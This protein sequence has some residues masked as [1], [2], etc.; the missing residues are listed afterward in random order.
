MKHRERQAD[1]GA[2]LPS[3]PAPR[4]YEPEALERRVLLSINTTPLLADRSVPGTQWTYA[5]T[6]GNGVS[7]TYV[8]TVIG[9]ATFNGIACIEIDSGSP[10]KPSALQSYEGQDSAGD[11]VSY[12]SVLNYTQMDV[13]SPYQG[14]IPLVA[15]AGTPYTDTYTDTDTS[16]NLA[17][18]NTLTSVDM[19]TE[20][21]TLVSETP[22]VLQ[23]PAGSYSAYDFR[24]VQ[25]ITTP[26]GDGTSTTTT[27][28]TDSWLAP[29]VGLV[30]SDT[31][32]A[33]LELSAFRNINDKLAFIQQPSNVA[34]GGTVQPA[35][36]VAVEDSA[37][38]YDTSA[39]GTVAISLNTITGTGTLTGTLTEPV[40]NGFATFSDLSVDTPGQY[41]LA[42]ADTAT[43]PIA[44]ATSVPFN[45]QDTR[46]VFQVAPAKSNEPDVALAPALKVELQDGKGNLI[47][48][49]DGSVVT[50]SLVGVNAANPITG[51]TATLSGGIAT[52][53]DVV[54][55]KP[56]TYQLQAS[57]AAGDIVAT[58]DKFGVTG[59][60]LV[61][62]VQPRSS[63]AASPLLM[64]VEA[65]T[66][67]GKPDTTLSETVQLSLNVIAG[68]TS[69]VLAGNAT[70]TLVGGVATFNAASAVSI[71]LSGTYTLTATAI[72]SSGVDYSVK[73]ATSGKFKI[74]G[75]TLREI[76]GEVGSQKQVS[77]DD[78]LSITAANVVAV[79][80]SNGVML[81]T[82]AGLSPATAAVLDGIKWTIV[83]NSAD[84]AAG[85][86][87]TITQ[88]ASKPLQ[89]TVDLNGEGS[90]NVICY[91][92]SNGNG[93]YD[94]G[95]ELKVFHLAEVGVVVAAGAGSV[96]TDNAD[97]AAR[98]YLTTAT[99]L[100]DGN[101]AGPY[102]I[103]MSEPVQLIGGGADG[104]I[105]VDKI[106]MGFVQ[107]GLSDNFAV[108]YK[109]G[110]VATTRL[111]AGSYPILDS[112]YHPNPGEPSAIFTLPIGKLFPLPK[113]PGPARD[114]P[115]TADPAGGEDRTVT[116]A[117]SPSEEFQNTSRSSPAS[118][119]S[120][121]YTFVAY[122]SAYSD[123]FGQS[124]DGYLAVNWSESFQFSSVLGH[125][126]NLGSAVSSTVSVLPAPATLES[127]G[128]KT[129]GPIFPE[130]SITI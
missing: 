55:T 11:Y 119:T 49:S 110:N 79:P 69:A 82:A 21:I 102:A 45:V 20:V 117:D 109:N 35:V 77:T 4:R 40:V 127:L 96:T 103:Q 107:D 113:A 13:Y 42:A 14:G 10:T 68:H 64:K 98:P 91:Y 43:P 33:T 30:Q 62:L 106:H 47:T 66:P 19:E 125:W 57:D 12:G 51:T 61:Y 116:T 92:D 28:T 104:M 60:K 22:T 41:S 71:N 29:G 5:S 1:S 86:D 23:V 8:Q 105:G 120:G 78:D 50:L 83:R 36:T 63:N 18:G 123:D 27:T 54:L 94:A 25:T 15:T 100:Q 124:Y 112:S 88:D 17:T 46:L 122:L 32:A 59:D 24:D 99:I 34:A 44:P 67:K 111:T 80:Q 31:G 114:Q 89:A 39:T 87:P 101:F 16:G 121:G 118:S 90:F 6:G 129:N 26:D 9:P 81:M 93:T 76:I 84:I 70:A 97:F 65:L 48:T 53:S 130:S 126:V 3:K 85:A 58:T 7:G 56:G 72:G 38:N 115:A 95:E 74:N 52:F 2:R 37:G 108:Q 75:V 128:A 73:P